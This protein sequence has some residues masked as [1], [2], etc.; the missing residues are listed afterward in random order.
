MQKITGFV[1]FML[2]PPFVTGFQLSNT[3]KFFSIM[4]FFA[5]KKPEIFKMRR[6]LKI[7]VKEKRDEN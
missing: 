4:Q 6:T 1:T 3:A 2:C 5:G 7:K